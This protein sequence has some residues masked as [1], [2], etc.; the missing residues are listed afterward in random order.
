MIEIFTEKVSADR[1][2]VAL[3]VANVRFVFARK[4]DGSVKLISRSKPEAQVRD[5][6]ACWV[7]K[8]LFNAAYRKACAILTR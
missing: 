5:P 4:P 2:K 1:S 3:R 8:N 7:P 6:D